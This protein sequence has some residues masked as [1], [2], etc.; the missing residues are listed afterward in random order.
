M[1]GNPSLAQ[2]LRELRE[3][4]G[5]SARRIE[6]LGGPSR[7]MLGEYEAGTRV[8]TE[9]AVLRILQVLD[10]PAHD[11][12]AVQIM[13]AL[14]PRGGLTPEQYRGL[15]DAMVE[16]VLKTDG[17]PRTDVLVL[18]ARNDVLAILR[19]TIGEPHGGGDAQE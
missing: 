5:L 14:N 4:R 2:L 18:T 1:S 11:P 3:R 9:T 19:R 8:P 17:R 10:I 7:K 12:Q 16:L 13:D 15:V 6:Q